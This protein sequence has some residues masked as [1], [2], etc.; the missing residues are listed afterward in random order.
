MKLNDALSPRKSLDARRPHEP[1]A[2]R[3]ARQVS[4]L[5]ELLRSEHLD[6]ATR[7]MVERVLARLSTPDQQAG[8]AP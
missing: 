3:L 1:T 6:E 7:A 8:T 5:D 2:L 4:G